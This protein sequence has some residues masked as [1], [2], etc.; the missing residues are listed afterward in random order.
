[1]VKFTAPDDN[2][3]SARWRDLL[4]TEH[5]ALETL[6]A[7]E[8]PAAVSR[9]VDEGP[10]RFLELQRFDRLGL[11]G[12]R[13]LVSLASLDGEFVGNAAAQVA[14]THVLAQGGGVAATYRPHEALEGPK[15]IWAA[16]AIGI[17]AAATLEFPECGVGMSP[18]HAIGTT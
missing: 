9:V 4:L 15:G 6:R 7:A 1:L 2:P 18:E 13:A 14:Q 8:I 12:R 11:R 17:H 16:D 5:L 10:Q 3:V